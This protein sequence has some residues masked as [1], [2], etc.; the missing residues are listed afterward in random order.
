[1]GSNNGHFREF[2]RF[3][4]DPEKKVLYADERLVDQQLKEIELLCLLTERRG[5]LLTKDEILDQIWPGAYVE[6][7]NLSQHIY[8]LRKTFRE[9]G[10]TGEL[11]QT[12][13]RRGYRF[14]G[15]IKSDENA[16]VIER[17]SISKTFIE[18]MDISEEPN[19]QETLVSAAP[20]GRRAILLPVAACI[21][22]AAVLAAGVYLY[23]LTVVNANQPIRSI[24]VLPLRPLSSNDDQSIGLG[25]ADAL[26]TSLGGI[27]E[28]E[29]R[30]VNSVSNYAEKPTEPL[31]I[32]KKLGV[33]A[34]IDGTVQR[35][36]GNL[37]VTLR[38]IRASDGKQL[39][40]DTFDRP[41]ASIFALQDSMASS[42]ANAL[43][44]KL[45]VAPKLITENLDAYRAYL[46]AQYLF[47]RR[48]TSS[49]GQFYRKAIELDPNFAEAWAGLAAVYAMGDD[50]PR[51]AET[52]DRAVSIKPTLAE[53]H[54]V[55]GF[56]RMFLYWDWPEAEKSLTRA[57]ELDRNSVEAHHWLGTYLTTR[58]R[59]DEAEKVLTRA[60]ELYPT[61]ANLIADLGLVYFHSGQFE[62]AEIAFLQART[63]EERFATSRLRDLY[64]KQGRDS[65]A[66]RLQLQLVCPPATE[67]TKCRESVTRSFEKE[68]L[69]ATM[70]ADLKR[71]YRGLSTKDV[72][73]EGVAHIWYGI[74]L[75]HAELGQKAEALNALNRSL[76]LK[77]PFEQMNFNA[78]FLAVESR[79]DNIRSEP[80]FQE[81]LR[82]LRL[83]S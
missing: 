38:L 63:I 20:K 1:M 24:A 50:M 25:F 21:C 74:A 5:E 9:F 11:I 17:H 59:F 70:A 69:R 2:G 66:F 48:E 23:S 4:L 8:R 34:I 75:N 67:G 80:E 35:A 42:T 82:K 51:A 19:R 45:S 31:E 81:I 53:A 72:A 7:S 28:L 64:A 61:S 46:Q 65:D 77:M 57:V 78:P 83:A 76:T 14:V 71:Y 39:W 62:K 32:A 22:V 43:A 41:E 60:V 56:I 6:E 73:A 68:G 36:N 40:A 58:R 52:A 33:D 16:L 37:R 79:F 55:R 29:V 18:E 54:A 13:P 30:S 12:I 47:R 27:N 3:R 15:D 49:S 44:L 10:E 26:I